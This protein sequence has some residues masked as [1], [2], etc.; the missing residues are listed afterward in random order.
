MSEVSSEGGK[1]SS[2]WKEWEGSGDEE[3]A[4]TTR[5]LFC[6]ASFPTPLQA[7]QHDSDQFGFDL[8]GFVS[9]V[10]CEVWCCEV[11]DLE[12]IALGR[13]GHGH[14]GLGGVS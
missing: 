12:G 7:L 4:C 14:V 3:E 8:M 10:S 6:T 9:Q 11:K 2:S 1:G 5:S 13:P